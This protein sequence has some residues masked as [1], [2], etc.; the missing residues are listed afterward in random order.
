MF[1]M[2]DLP[3]VKHFFPSVVLI[4]PLSTSFLLI[5][6]HLSELYML[7]SSRAQDLNYFFSTV[8]PLVLSVNLKT[9][10]LKNLNLY[11]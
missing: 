3:L 7:E 8:T 4:L 1:E 11:D 2:D 6:S 10:C 9:I 5:A